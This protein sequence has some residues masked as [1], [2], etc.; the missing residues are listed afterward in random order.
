[1]KRLK[2]TQQA[3][4]A[5]MAKPKEP[6]YTRTWDDDHKPTMTEG[7]YV[8]AAAQ[9]ADKMQLSLE[10]AQAQIR[11]DFNVVPR[12]IRMH[13]HLGVRAARALRFDQQ[14]EALRD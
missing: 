4:V 11:E 14:E 13:P 12:K 10:D 7:I 3:A 5:P 9:L 1:M 6:T 8:L 2:S